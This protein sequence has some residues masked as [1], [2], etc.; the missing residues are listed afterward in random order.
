VLERL[1]ATES[2][3][4]TDLLGGRRHADT[5]RRLVGL[6]LLA[7]LPAA[8]AGPSAWSRRDTRDRR[9]GLAY[10]RLNSTPR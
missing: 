6:G 7:V 5:S 9:V 3:D 2:L 10:A 8:A 1:E 4:A